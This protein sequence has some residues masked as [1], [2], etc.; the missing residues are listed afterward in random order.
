M[1]ATSKDELQAKDAQRAASKRATFDRLAQK[2]R[3]EREI[4]VNLAAEGAEP[5]E[6]VLLFRAIGA[7]EYDDLLAKHPP[8]AKQKVEGASY[9]IDT[10]A[11]ALIAKVCVDPEMSYEESKSLWDSE[12]W[13]RGEVMTLFGNAVELCNQGLNVPFTGS[14]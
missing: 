6:V 9:N 3:A 1:A 8:N 10:F 7:K 14:A 5:D 2:R 4:R 13:S 12:E 11:P